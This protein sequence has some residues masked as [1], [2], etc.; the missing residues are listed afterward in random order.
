M[1]N[2]HKRWKEKELGW[3]KKHHPQYS[4]KEIG[5][6]FGRSESSVRNLIIIKGWAKRKPLW[7]KREIEFLRGNIN[8]ISI[9]EISTKLSRSEG[10]IIAK[11]NRIKGP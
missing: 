1:K 9:D 2:Q 7:E 10:S 11:Y 8:K 5:R 6:K 3:I 4:Y